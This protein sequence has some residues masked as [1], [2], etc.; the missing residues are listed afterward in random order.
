ME[1]GRSESRQP[2]WEAEAAFRAARGWL[3][4]GS[5]KHGEHRA[6]LGSV[7]E[8]KLMGLVCD[9]VCGLRERGIQKH[10]CSWTR[11]LW[12]EN[13]HRVLR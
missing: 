9:P 3:A 5:C 11:A 6:R 10:L 8:A 12:V 2:S 7:L 4:L 1:K 13:G